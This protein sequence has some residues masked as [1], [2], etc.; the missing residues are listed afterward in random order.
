VVLSKYQS[1]RSPLGTPARIDLDHVTLVSVQAE[2][3]L[4]SQIEHWDL[5]WLT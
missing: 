2:N 5:C 1:S 4:S 3:R